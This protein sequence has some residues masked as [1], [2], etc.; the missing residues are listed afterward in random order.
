MEVIILNDWFEWNGKRCTEYGIH[1]SEQPPFTVP[2]E[3]IT[4]TSVPGRP[5]SFATLEGDD[6]YD[7]MI[8]TATCFI[9]DAAR[10]PEIA[11]WLRGNGT[12]TFA[13]RQGGF[14]YARIT[15]QISFDKILRGNPHRS[16]VVNFRCQPF[17][18]HSNNAAVTV[19]T[20]GA[21]IK[22]PGTIYAEPILEIELTADAEVTMGGYLF[23]LTGVTGKVKM[24]CAHMEVTKNYASQLTHMTGEFPR[25]PTTGAY[26]N[27]TG[28]VTSIKI[29]PNWRS[30]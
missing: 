3:R 2:N 17:F 12:V 9:T 6:V 27:W 14:Y 1:V 23:E 25:I 8:L 5:G 20:S 16:F 11:A 18:Y 21:F 28:G 7:D 4:F 24:D 29:T 22:N 10:L 30:L 26:V 13:N 19:T 15:N